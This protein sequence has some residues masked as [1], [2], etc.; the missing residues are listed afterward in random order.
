M[1]TDIDEC[2]GD[3]SPCNSN[4]NCFNMPGSFRCE[5]K[6]GFNLDPIT[7][8]CVGKWWRDDFV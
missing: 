3:Q 4:Q 7:N 1:V 5:C 8:A 6:V 2:Y